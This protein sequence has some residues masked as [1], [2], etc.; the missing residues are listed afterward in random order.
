MPLE[1]G[2]SPPTTPCATKFS[3]TVLSE[4]LDRTRCDMTKRICNASQPLDPGCQYVRD[5]LCECRAANRLGHRV[6]LHHAEPVEFGVQVARVPSP[7][8]ATMDSPACARSRYSATSVRSRLRRHP[9]I[10]F[11]TSAPLR[12]IPNGHPTAKKPRIFCEP[13]ERFRTNVCKTPS[14]I[15]GSPP[16]LTRHRAG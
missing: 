4:R 9:A 11:V 10:Q 13:M 15:A 6:L 8:A 2:P 16:N 7:I 5:P 14:Q 3:S 1:P 12:H